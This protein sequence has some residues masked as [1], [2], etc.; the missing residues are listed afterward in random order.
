MAAAGNSSVL[1]TLGGA[2]GFGDIALPRSDDG[3]TR[4]DARS[5]FDAGILWFGTR[6]A[7]DAIWINTNGTISFGAA[8]D[9]YHSLG[10]DLP[11]GDVIA[12][13]WGDIDTRLDGE[14]AESGPIWVDIDPVT[15]R[16]TV[17]WAHVGAYRYDATV[18]NLFQVELTDRGGGDIAVTLRYDRITWDRGSAAD[19]AGAVALLAATRLTQPVLLGPALTLDSAAGNT[20]VA[21]LWHWDLRGGT[22]SGLDPAMGLVRDGTAGADVLDGTAG[23]DILRGKADNDVL[24]GADGDDW[25]AGGDGADTLNGGTGQDSL[26]GGDTAAD[27]RDVIYGGDGDD[28]IDGGHGNDLVYGGAGHDL[29]AGGFGADEL[30]GQD[31]NDTL[32]GAAFSDLIFGGDGDDFLNGGFGHDRLNGGSGADRYYHLGIFDHGSDWVQDYNAADG[33]LLVWGGAASAR[34]ADFQVNLTETAAAG[35]SGVPEAFVIHRPTGQIVWAL[36]D[37]GDEAAIWL[38]IGTSTYDIG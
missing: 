4:I 5:V 10:A 7:G 16:L 38:R 28:D 33:D 18:T 3:S 23:D 37:G 32:T 2:D 31:G 22:V 12:A 27:L 20:G 29:I 30:I 36:V 26:R 8:F 17:T 34:P 14:G 25:L 1:R 9:G 6:H 13:F 19:D 11:A 15:D 35:Q 21:G 24:R